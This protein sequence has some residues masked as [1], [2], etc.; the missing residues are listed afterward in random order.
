[1]Q[2]LSRQ[3]REYRDQLRGRY[4]PD[5][6]W[7]AVMVHGGREYRVR[8]R[9]AQ[10][11]GNGSVLETL[12][13][14]LR[15]VGNPLGQNGRRDLLFPSYVFLCCQMSDIVYM[16]IDSYKEVFSILGRAF[17]IP[18]VIADQE[19]THLKGVLQSY[20]LPILSRSLHV[21]SSA[22]VMRGLMEGMH[23]R[24]FEYNAHYVKLETCFSFFDNGT[25]ILVTVPKADVQ[26]DTSPAR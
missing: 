22:V 1:M 26:L 4:E 10:D 6:Q 7:Y 5:T 25:S 21:G 17:R 3:E 19:M 8:E 14:E 23:G 15:P 18:S 2:M 12:L 24:I 13:P 9:I 20:P 11:L 16:T